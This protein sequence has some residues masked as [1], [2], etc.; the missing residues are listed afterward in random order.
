[1]ARPESDLHDPD[2]AAWQLTV[3]STA[4]PDVFAARPGSAFACHTI[5]FRRQADGRMISVHV[6]DSTFVRLDP[7]ASQE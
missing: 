4:D 5:T 2:T 1:V 3:E 6:M 7:P